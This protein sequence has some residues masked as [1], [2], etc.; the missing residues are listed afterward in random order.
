MDLNRKVVDGVH[1]GNANHFVLGVITHDFVMVLVDESPQVH[2]IELAALDNIF[3]ALV[4][5]NLARNSNWLLRTK[6]ANCRKT[7][8]GPDG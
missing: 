8:P 3:N 2:A 7:A 5:A 1:I 4:D 6:P